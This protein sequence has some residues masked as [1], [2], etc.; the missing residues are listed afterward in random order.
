MR[1]IIKKKEEEFNPIFI[2]GAFRSGTTLLARALSV[3]KD[4]TIASD[5]YF[6]FFKAFRNEI[7]HIHNYT[8]FDDNSPVSDNFFSPFLGVN[9]YIYTST[10]NIPIKHQDI[11]KIK[12]N[13]ATFCEVHAPKLISLSSIVLV[14]LI[15]AI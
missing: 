13:I 14:S 1:E 10:F 9:K 11:K 2:T 4:I 15:S 5:A 8:D 7:F 3:H 12:E 6:Q